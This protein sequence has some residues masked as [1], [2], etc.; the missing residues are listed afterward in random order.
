MNTQR[1]ERRSN[2]SEV[3]EIAGTLDFGWEWEEQ[4]INSGLYVRMTEEGN[5]KLSINAWMDLECGNSCYEDNSTLYEQCSVWEMSSSSGCDI[6]SA[7][8]SI[9]LSVMVKL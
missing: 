7:S 3:E 2:S 4:R 8:V 1:R 9:S 6:P 5:E